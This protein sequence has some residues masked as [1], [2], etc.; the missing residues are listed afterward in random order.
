MQQ[1]AMFK[2]KK[3]LSFVAVQ[4]N[5]CKKMQAPLAKVDTGTAGSWGLRPSKL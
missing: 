1:Q 4:T 3:K 2:P 5:A